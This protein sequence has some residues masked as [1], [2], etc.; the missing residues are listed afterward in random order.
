[1]DNDKLIQKM[2]EDMEIRGF[3]EYTKSNYLNKTKHMIKYFNKPIRRL[4][5]E[6]ITEDNGGNED[7]QNE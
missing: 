7:G 1:M 5:A 3:S 4:D 2:K 6:K